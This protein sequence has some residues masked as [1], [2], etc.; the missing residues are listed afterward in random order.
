MEGSPGHNPGRSG[1]GNI[2][3][4]A[5][6]AGPPP[7]GRE[8]RGP[9]ASPGPDPESSAG[10]GVAGAGPAGPPTGEEDDPVPEQ[11]LRSEGD[12]P[13]PSSQSGAYGSEPDCLLRVQRLLTKSLE[14]S[15]G[16]LGGGTTLEEIVSLCF[17][18][19]AQ[20][21]N[22]N[23]LSDPSPSPLPQEDSYYGTCSVHGTPPPWLRGTLYRV[24]PGLWEV[25]SRQLRHVLDGF[26][27]V[28]AVAFGGPGERT[29]AQQR[30]IDSE[31]Y[32]AAR[33]GVLLVDK[34]ASRRRFAGWGE[35]AQERIR[36]SPRGA[37][38]PRPYKAHC[39]GALVLVPPEKAGTAKVGTAASKRRSLIRRPSPFPFLPAHILRRP[40]WASSTSSRAPARSSPL[41]AR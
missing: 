19:P 27:V 5:G 6:P 4:G 2:I 14:V 21:C 36:V 13:G 33:M 32:R 9:E 16:R 8:E 30:F 23:A 25:G 3:A 10:N 38:L 35:W 15:L 17:N 29:I 11:S 24:G 20:R 7:G 22:E 39:K 41:G 26:A 34:F 31:P 37:S 12:P 28:G 1:G 18:W 40:C